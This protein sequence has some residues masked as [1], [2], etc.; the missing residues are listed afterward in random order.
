MGVEGNEKASESAG[1]FGSI[2]L[3]NCAINSNSKVVYLK[4]SVKAVN[5]KDCAL[6]ITNGKKYAVDLL[7]DVI[8]VVL[9]GSTIWGNFLNVRTIQKGNIALKMLNF[10]IYNAS[11]DVVSCSIHC[12]DVM[13]KDG[14]FESCS[15]VTALRIENFMGQ[16][17]FENCSSLSMDGV[18]FSKS[19][20]YRIIRLQCVNF[21]LRNIKFS[22]NQVTSGDAF[23]IRKSIGSINNI[24]FKGNN[25]KRAFDLQWGSKVSI[26]NISST[27]PDTYQ[28]FVHM[29]AEA[30]LDISQATFRGTS[31]LNNAGRD[32]DAFIYTLLSSPKKIRSLSMENIVFDGL[33][34]TP[35]SKPTN[36]IDAYKT[37]V[38]LKGVTIKN[39]NFSTAIDVFSGN[40]TVDNVNIVG[41]IGNKEHVKLSDA[42]RGN[43]ISMSDTM[44]QT[45]GPITKVSGFKP[46]NALI[47]NYALEKNNFK[48]TTLMMRLNESA[49]IE[50]REGEL[51]KFGDFIDVK[52]P[53][54][55]DVVSHDT[56]YG[57]VDKCD[58][59]SCRVPSSGSI[60]MIANKMNVIPALILFPVVYFLKV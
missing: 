9:N 20:F 14:R 1:E 18:S 36:I 23:D 8:S 10:K 4:G 47:I 22:G 16:E 46:W 12:S 42:K 25:M 30:S 34:P 7:S 40:I 38:T 55:S 24:H 43:S 3:K 35:D 37:N 49:C 45:G 54:G 48:N 15:G 33:K 44:I 51:Y 59:V 41:N 21:N 39:C 52:C 17:G 2:R 13:I 58:C 50:V 19:T 26:K 32:S 6:N 56:I 60:N 5:I 31:I 53:N 11:G 29:F 28:E 57:C 27:G